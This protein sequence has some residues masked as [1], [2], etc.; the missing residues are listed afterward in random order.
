MAGSLI[1]YISYGMKVKPYN[2][3]YIDIAERATVGLCEAAN[4]GSYLVDALPIRK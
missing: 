4:P 1:L 3:P 2:D